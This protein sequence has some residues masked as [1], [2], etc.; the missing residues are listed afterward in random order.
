M[1]LQVTPASQPIPGSKP[2]AF[3]GVPAVLGLPGTAGVPDHIR[4]ALRRLD[5]YS[6]DLDSDLLDATFTDYG[7]LNLPTD[8]IAERSKVAFAACRAILSTAS[9]PFLLVRDSRFTPANVL[10]TLEKHPQLTVVQLSARANLQE[11]CE[12]QKWHSRTALKRVL[13]RL[14]SEK[15]KILG[16]RCGKKEEFELIAAQSLMMQAEDLPSLSKADLYLSIDLSIFDPFTLPG[17]ADPE[18]GGLTW[19]QFAEVL[20]LVPWGQVRACDVVGL[21][22]SGDHT[23][24]SSLVAAKVVREMILSLTKKPLR[25]G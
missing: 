13:E 20:A 16:A 24:L 21:E 23:G 3:S 18:P 8:T 6:P 22:P 17:V 25:L 2:S 9:I 19:E 4:A 14:P 7:N 5:T 1:S 15:V 12:G 11:E 10:A